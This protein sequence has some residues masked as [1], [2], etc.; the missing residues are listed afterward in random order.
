MLTD[1]LS[2]KVTEKIVEAKFTGLEKLKL[3]RVKNGF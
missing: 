2:D 1:L 3:E